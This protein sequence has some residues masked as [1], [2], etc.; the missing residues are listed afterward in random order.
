LSSKAHEL[1]DWGKIEALATDHQEPLTKFEAVVSLG[2]LALVEPKHQLL[3]LLASFLSDKESRVRYGAMQSLRLLAEEHPENALAAA[4]RDFHDE[5]FGVM[6]ELGL[7]NKIRNC[8][9][10]E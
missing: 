1:V 8:T 2:K 4:P 10:I 7:I 3:K 5:D 6:F 9:R